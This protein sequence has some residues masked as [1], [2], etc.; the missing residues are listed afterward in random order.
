MNPA[1]AFPFALRSALCGG[2]IG[3]GHRSSN[4]GYELLVLIARWRVYL[5]LPFHRLLDE[6]S[7]N[8][9][10]VAHN[11]ARHNEGNVSVQFPL[12]AYS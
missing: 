12:S 2:V 10:S 5:R 8:R 3:G 1:P 7:S 9:R 6:R 4:E 11:A